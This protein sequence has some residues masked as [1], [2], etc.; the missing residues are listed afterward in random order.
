MS[1]KVDDHDEAEVEFGHGE[2]PVSEVLQICREHRVDH[3]VDVRASHQY[4]QTHPHDQQRPVTHQRVR[5]Q[6]VDP[7]LLL[8]QR[9]ARPHFFVYLLALAHLLGG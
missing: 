2:A 6:E 8:V 1:K 9:P 3:L 5:A 7:L 4:K